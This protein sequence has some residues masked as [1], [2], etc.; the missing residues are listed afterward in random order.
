VKKTAKENVKIHKICS[1]SLY[2]IY[3]FLLFPVSNS[4]AVYC[5]LRNSERGSCELLIAY[6]FVTSAE[7]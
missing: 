6:V 1:N 2:V 7:T 5:S 4:I 3:L